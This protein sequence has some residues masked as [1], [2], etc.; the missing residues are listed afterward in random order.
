VASRHA[1]TVARQKAA[2]NAFSGLPDRVAW[3]NDALRAHHEEG[4]GPPRS[5]PF[6]IPSAAQ[7]V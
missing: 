4:G 2:L 7:D 3:E 5:G 6:G 1:S